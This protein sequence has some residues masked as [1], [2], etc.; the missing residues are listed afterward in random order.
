[1]NRSLNLILVF[2]AAIASFT[3]SFHGQTVIRSPQATGILD[4]QFIWAKNEANV[5]EYKAGYWIGYSIQRLMEENS[6][7]GTFNSDEK[8][9]HPSL[10]EIIFGIQ[11]SNPPQYDAGASHRMIKK[12]IGILFHYAG[13]GSAPIDE[14]I[15]S[16]LSLHVDLKNDPLIWIGAA[17]IE[18]SVQHFQQ[19]YQQASADEVKKDIIASIGMH[20]ES[21]QAFKFLKDI[22]ESDGQ[23]SLREQAV[24]WLGQQHNEKALSVLMRAARSDKS[25][26]VRENAIFAVSEIDNPSSVDS[27]IVL[28]KGGNESEMRN[29]AMFWLAQRASDKAVKTITAIAEDND[30]Y[31]IQKQ[32]VFAL[33]QLSDDESIPALIKIARTHRNP[34]IRKTAIFWLGQSENQAALDAIV[35]IIKK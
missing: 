28:A 13:T 33:S 32:A 24:F 9:N 19:V 26:D 35:D 14:I 2:I 29:K 23:A 27:L 17:E 18:Q 6:F 25:E 20:E 15:V 8:R 34:D 4:Q 21:A 31:E 30:D 10:T 3:T 22:V 5:R 1:V 12:D 11:E 7:T 16:N